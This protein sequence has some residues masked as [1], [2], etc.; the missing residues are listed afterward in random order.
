MAKAFCNVISDK[1]N[2]DKF[3]NLLLIVL[4]SALGLLLVAFFAPYLS[5]SGNERFANV[6]LGIVEFTVGMGDLWLTQPG[7]IRPPDDPYLVLSQH[8]LG[9]DEDGFRLPARPAKKYPIIAL[10]DSYTEA[11]NVAQPWPDVLATELGQAV[12]NLG[13]RGYGPQ[14]EAIVMQEY[15]IKN[16]P[17]VVVI[18]FFGGNDIS[19]AGTFEARKNDFILP[20]LVELTLDRFNDQNRP[21]ESNQD[22]YRYPVT[23][24]IGEQALPIAFLSSYVSWQNLE[25]DAFAQS[26]NLSLIVQ[27]WKDIQNTAKPDT[28]VLL[29]Y[30]PS[31]P[32]IYL[33]YVIPEHRE[34]VIDGLLRRDISQ[35]GEI[36]SRFDDPDL[37]WDALMKRLGAVIPVLKENA[38]MEGLAFLDLS[39]AF[40]S[41]AFSGDLLYYVYDTHWNQTGHD[42]VGKMIAQALNNGI[43]AK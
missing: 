32:Q 8:Q 22:W 1:K 3:A 27:S 35:P 4:G 26:R 19:N 21:W 11:A 36:L 28:C 20:E 30:F 10:G 2:L 38:E 17:D 43:C 5:R 23:I 12:R 9:W 13:F 39:P 15:G 7:S 16:Q 41:A 14:E 33:P 37:T 24:Q 42:L 34:Q 25:A 18:G 6:E 29:V 31:K 40:A